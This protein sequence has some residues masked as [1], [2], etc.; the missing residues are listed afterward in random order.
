[1][2]RPKQRPFIDSYTMASFWAEDVLPPPQR[3]VDDLILWLGDN[4][5]AYETPSVPRFTFSALGSAL[6][7]K[8]RRIQLPVSVGC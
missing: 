1:M 8:I 2:Q 7:S 4:Q 3:Q 6:R 5:V